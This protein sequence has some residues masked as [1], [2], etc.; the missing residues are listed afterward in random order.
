MTSE[1]AASADNQQ[2]R[3]KMKG[4]LVGFVDGE[5]AFTISI[6]KNHTMKTGWQVF[7]E[8]V[9]T[10]GKKS[11]NSLYLF[12]DYFRCGNVYINKRYDNHR[13]DLYRYCVRSLVDLNATIVPFFQENGLR[14]S[15]AVDFKH[16]CKCL[17]LIQHKKHLTLGGL[18]QISEIALLMNRK[19]PSTFL[20]SSHTIRRTIYD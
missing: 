13:E 14:T 18:T 19:Q 17:D 3:L 5:G 12:K 1:N 15:K 10:Q 4:W 8:F 7:P 16:F 6:F 20:E 11:K 9:V 2:E